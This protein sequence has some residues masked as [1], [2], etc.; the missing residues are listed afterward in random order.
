MLTRQNDLEPT[1]VLAALNAQVVRT[2]GWTLN[3]N[4]VCADDDAARARLLSPVQPRG[5]YR[6]ELSVRRG[7]RS[8]AAPCRTPACSSSA[9]QPRSRNSLVVLDYPLPG[10]GFASFL[11]LSGFKKF[12]DN[13]TFRMSEKVVPRL[14]PETSVDLVCTVQHDEITVLLGGE[15]LVEYRGDMGRLSVPPE[16]AVPSSRSMFL[17]THQGGFCVSRW[18]IAPLANVAAPELPPLLRDP[19]PKPFAPPA[20]PATP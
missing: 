17:G 4:Q 6:V 2:Q 13:P 18:N 5:N 8:F 20:R 12:E 10:R 7:P 11:T 14:E 19:L 3:A 16:W 9:C 15:K 1:N